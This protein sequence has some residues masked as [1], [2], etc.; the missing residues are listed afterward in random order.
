MFTVTYGLNPIVFM[1][2]LTL[3]GSFWLKSNYFTKYEVNPTHEINQAP[4]PLLA[5]MRT[6]QF[7]TCWINKIEPH[8]FGL[9]PMV[10]AR[11]TW[12][13][14]KEIVQL[15]RQKEQ[16]LQD[17]QDPVSAGRWATL[18]QWLVAIQ[19]HLAALQVVVDGRRNAAGLSIT[20]IR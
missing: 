19:A 17:L 14:D 3:I 10:A 18:Q 4:I 13:I 11:Q 12:E 7:C 1:W 8:G 2:I 20:R 6:G 16:I 15:T 5:R 9:L